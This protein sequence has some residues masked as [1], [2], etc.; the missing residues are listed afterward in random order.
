MAVSYRYGYSFSRRVYFGVRIKFMARIGYLGLHGN[1]RQYYGAGM[2]TVRDIMV[3]SDTVC[4]MG[5]GLYQTR[6]LA[7]GQPLQSLDYI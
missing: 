3:L 2:H 4:D 1:V 6:I 5:R 7:G